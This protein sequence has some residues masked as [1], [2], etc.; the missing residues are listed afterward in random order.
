MIELLNKIS[1]KI[2][3]EKLIQVQDCKHFLDEIS[4]LESNPKYI[5]YYKHIYENIE[6]QPGNSKNS[7]VFWCLDKV[8]DLDQTQ[9]VQFDIKASLPDI[10][11][12]VPIHV[13][14]QVIEYIR[15]RYGRDNVSQMITFQTMKGARALKEVFRAYGDMSFEEINQITRNVIEEHKITDQLEKMDEPSIIR[16]CLENQP[17]D[18]EAWCVIDKDGNLSGQYADRFEQAIKLEGT[19]AAQSKHAA[20][21]IIAPE[22]LSNLCPMIYDSKTKQPIAG[23]EMNDLE[24][25]GLMKLDILGVA[26]LSKLMRISELTNGKFSLDVENIDFDDEQTWEL[27]AS[28]NTK[29]VFQLESRLGQSFAKKLGPENIDHLAGLT[30]LLRPGCL[31]TLENNSKS[32]TENYISIKNKELEPEYIHEKLKDVLS[33]TYSKNIYQEQSMRIATVFAGFSEVDSDTYIR[34]GIGKKK[35]DLIAKAKSMFMDGCKKIGLLNEEEAQQVFAGIESSARYQFNASH[36]YGYSYLSY[37]TAYAK[38][39]Y[40]KEFFTAYLEYS[41]DKIK[42]QQ[43]IYELVNNAKTMNIYVQPPNIT[44]MNCG[45]DLID[46]EIYFGLCDIKNVGTSVL[47]KLAVSIKKYEEFLGKPIKEWTWTEFLFLAPEIKINSLES[48]INVGACDS[49][50]M[51]RTEMMF[52]VNIVRELSNKELDWV[53]NNVSLKDNTLHEI[54]N[55][56]IDSGSGRGKACSNKNRLEKIADLIN[57]LSNPP[58]SL[59]DKA[60]QIS[61]ME[62]ELLGV[63]LTAS[64]LDECSTKYKA[65][66]SC[67]QYNDG[68]GK[69]NEKVIIAAKIDNVKIIKTKKGKNPGQEM[70]FVEASDDTGSIDCGVVFP[71]YWNEYKNMIIE[72]NKLLLCGHRNED[73]NSFILELVEQL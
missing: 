28:G 49:F 32:V 3:K 59:T 64:A 9:P 69:G 1:N 67:N 56:M 35:A 73:S 22:S 5:D 60:H 39:H 8:T 29:G 12:D 7:Y 40:P 30:A 36:S 13:R 25:L 43:E 27:I 63:I 11:V 55:C 61:Q 34:T 16:W 2:N 33:E 71:D 45:F 57:T 50:N 37:L 54:L 52:E 47:D 26:A 14:G 10:D 15:E 31:S 19:K 66:C 65:N 41:H 6:L 23:M 70:A 42:P 17:K 20:G 53:K 21:I 48:L 51:S 44:L 38:T 72:G 58:C 18:F 46:G 4:F 62:Y 24:S 68:Y